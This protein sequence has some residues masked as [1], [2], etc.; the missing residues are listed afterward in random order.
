MLIAG[1]GRSEPDRQLGELDRRF[2]RAA[3][4]NV[5]R[6]LGD[7]ERDRAVG[8]LGAERQMPRPLFRVH[9]QL[10]EPPACAAR[11]SSLETAE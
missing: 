2:R 3:P 1:V 5:A 7:T 4:P 9:G 6:G 11:R 8:L 10:R